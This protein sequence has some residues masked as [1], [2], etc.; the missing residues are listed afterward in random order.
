MS[1]EQLNT[2]LL[3]NLNKAMGINN[4]LLLMSIEIDKDERLVVENALKQ[5]SNSISKQSNKA[6]KLDKEEEW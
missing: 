1:R 2:D 6:K 3:I 5:L 4:S